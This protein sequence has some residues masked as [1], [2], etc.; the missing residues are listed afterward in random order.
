[1]KAADVMTQRVVSVTPNSSIVEAARI[2]L[3]NRISGLPVLDGSG[4]LVGIVTESDLLRRSEIGTERRRSHWVEFLTSPGLLAKEYVQSHGS[5]VS[6]VMTADPLT[7]REDASLAD[8]VLLMEKKRVKRLPVVRGE[9]VVGIV[10]RANLVRALVSLASET[11]EAIP[12]D[13]SIRERIL[14]EID[15][16]SWAP[17]TVNVFVRDGIVEFWGTIFD[18]RERQALRVAAENTPGVKEVRDHLVWSEPM[19]GLTFGLP[20][21]ERDNTDAS[22]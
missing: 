1:M 12:G 13:V 17:R 3:E 22:T 8:I 18:D 9:K 19:V 11:R 6:D 16:H 21:Q 5:K 2:M 7:I 20:A 14:A 10:S 4:K 15:R